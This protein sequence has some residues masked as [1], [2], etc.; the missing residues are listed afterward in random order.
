MIGL[1]SS[2][3]EDRPKSQS[4][5]AG[6]DCPMMVAVTLFPSRDAAFAS[7]SIERR[8]EGEN[9]VRGRGKAELAAALQLLP[10]RVQIE[11]QA[12]G[13][14]ARGFER[15]GADDREAKAGNALEAFVRGG[16]QAVDLPPDR[17]PPACRRNCSSHRR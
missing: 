17:R 16:D 13:A 12:A 5:H 14:A 7:Q 1:R 2:G 4:L 9:D 3:R 11:T 15:S 6:E 8:G 10:L